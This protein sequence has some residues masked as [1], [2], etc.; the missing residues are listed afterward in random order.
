MIDA[1]AAVKPSIAS[2]SLVP[3]VLVWAAYASLGAMNAIG[4]DAGVYL[5]SGEAV[6][7]GAP[8]YVRLWD[9]KGPILHLLNAIG[10][11]MSPGR[12]TGTLLLEA[13]LISASL[14]YYQHA[15]RAFSPRRILPATVAGVMSLLVVY[16]G[17]D[18]TETAA[19]PLQLVAYVAF[20]QIATLPGARRLPRLAVIGAALAWCALLRPNTAIGVGVVALVLAADALRSHRWRDHAALIG[21]TAIVAVPVL[22]LLIVTGA[23]DAWISAYL[24]FNSRHVARIGIH[25]RTFGAAVLVMNILRMPLLALSVLLVAAMP[26]SQRRWAQLTG[27]ERVLLAAFVADL[28]AAFLS[29][30]P[31]HHYLVTMIPA[32]MILCAARMDA[33]QFRGTWRRTTRALAATLVIVGVFAAAERIARDQRLAVAQS[34]R[35]LRVVDRIRTLTDSSDFLLV[36]GAQPKYNFLSGRRPPSAYAYQYPLVTPGYASRA[37]SRQFTE[38][39]LSRPPSLIIDALDP[40]LC[41]LAERCVRYDSHVVRD[42]IALAEFRAWVAANYRLIGTE[43]GLRFFRMR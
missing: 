23:I 4:T 10:T 31:F 18:L 25:E 28:F 32:W 14:V 38:D 16:E 33:L 26:R 2:A 24:E 29:G 41:P 17:G 37:R 30:R 3:L 20:W 36:Y 15:F 42:D 12:I 6:R 13:S 8:L 1:K 5:L 39:V 43:E 35:D 11:A 22:V 34:G 40:L 19:F 7:E 27:A 21:G 9:H